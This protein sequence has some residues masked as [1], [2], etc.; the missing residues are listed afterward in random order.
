MA[1]QVSASTSAPNNGIVQQAV[2]DNDQQALFARAVVQAKTDAPAESPQPAAPPPE[3]ES[4]T[5]SPDTKR[6]PGDKRTAEE[7]IK[8][9]P[10]LANL[11]APDKEFLKNGYTAAY[12][13]STFGL[14]S[15]GFKGVGDFEK[16]PDA[17]F[18]AA[19]ILE[20]IENFDANGNLIT[21]EGVGDGRIDGW[22]AERTNPR[23]HK[24]NP[25]SEAKN[26]TEAGRFQD[27]L[28]Y[29]YSSLKGGFEPYVP[30]A[31]GETT[32][33]KSLIDG[34]DFRDDQTTETVDG[35]KLT[36]Q[37][38]AVKSVLEDYKKRIDSGD[39][40]EGS[41]QYKFY[42]AMQAQSDITNGRSLETHFEQQWAGTSSTTRDLGEN[43]A[44][45]NGADMLHIIDPDKIS[46]AIDEAL[47]DPTVADDFNKATVA[48][49]HK[50]P[51]FNPEQSRAKLKAMLTSEGFQKHYEDLKKTDSKKADAEFQQLLSSYALLGGPDA[52]NE[53]GMELTRNGLTSQLNELLK[54][55]DS[56]PTELW[57]KATS[58]FIS[59]ALGYT[60]TATFFSQEIAN[61]ARDPA[62]VNLLKNKDFVKGLAEIQKRQAALVASGRMTT[63]DASIL[64]QQVKELSDKT[65]TNVADRNR[66][67]KFFDAL[68]K[69]GFLST[70][71]GFIAMSSAINK[72]TD[73]IGLNGDAQE[74]LSVA[75]GFMFWLANGNAQLKFGGEIAKF[76]KLGNAANLIGSY[77]DAGKQMLGAQGPR[78]IELR[79]WVNSRL[80]PPPLPN[81]AGASD[82]VSK[83]KSTMM[84]P[85]G[86]KVKLTSATGAVRILSSLGYTAF[87]AL[88]M[89]NAGIGLA[90]A[91]N[92]GD[93]A[94]AALNFASGTFFTGAGAAQIA[95]SIA[96]VKA[97]GPWISRLGFVGIFLTAVGLIAAEVVAEQKENKAQVDYFKT[98]EKLGLLKEGWG[99]NLEALTLYG[100]S[101]DLPEVGDGK[102]VLDT[103]DMKRWLA[104]YREDNK[105]NNSTSPHVPG[106]PFAQSAENSINAIVSMYGSGIDIKGRS[107][108]PLQGDLR[109]QYRSLMT[110]YLANVDSNDTAS[111]AAEWA[112]ARIKERL[113]AGFKSGGDARKALNVLDGWLSRHDGT[114]ELTALADEIIKELKLTPDP[115]ETEKNETRKPNGFSWDRVK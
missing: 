50:A 38:L 66:V 73:G 80:A 84:G 86:D 101:K 33:Y 104:D 18:R 45:A 94:V 63:I 11:S 37:E 30:P 4:Q 22:T 74:N 103:Y 77:I 54:N 67:T 31:V 27:F 55:P 60:T 71:T 88:A 100:Y 59:L 90:K 34:L 28:K 6:P 20:H 102:S 41:A 81:V 95:S 3:P 64:G 25:N 19:K 98:L 112:T 62:F 106:L 35:H 17:A 40:K 65:F 12:A 39:I 47:S 68:N 48:A 89:A 13:K 46:K 58:D 44:D 52:A 10:A 9:N 115:N 49:A 61:L 109:D 111:E 99:E 79:N 96:G 53:L 2:R 26:G 23:T 14:D 70:A 1:T 110:Y 5:I 15:V 97:A 75:N 56:I 8:G 113:G 16:D 51:G 57:E 93:R 42:Y 82:Y 29:G 43:K 83:L 108:P 85:E 92:P 76:L 21:G 36:V 7:I 107:V 105:G 78:D 72:L 32:D 114:I 69:N 87:G 91:D 24:L